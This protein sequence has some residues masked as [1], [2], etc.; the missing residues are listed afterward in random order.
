MPDKSFLAWPFFDDGHR[1]L[2]Q[3]LERWTGEVLP[4]L[5]EGAGKIRPRSSKEIDQPAKKFDG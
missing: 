3:E 5:L 2:A 4:P 1:D